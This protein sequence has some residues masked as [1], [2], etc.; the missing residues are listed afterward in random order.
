[1][2]ARLRVPL[3]ACAAIAAGMLAAC[4]ELTPTSPTAT[5]VVR[6]DLRVGSGD[7]ATSGKS[8]TV[9]YSGWL[10]DGSKTDHKGLLVDTSAGRDPFTFTLG[11]GD[12]IPGWDQG[13]PGMKVGG[14]RRLEIP[15]ALAYGATRNGPIPANSRLVF[16]VELLAVQ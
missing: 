10:Y 9:N 8:I 6:A 3:L 14:V 11:A 4:G 2:L 12:V 16:E 7:E 1:M 13:L 15:P 5:S